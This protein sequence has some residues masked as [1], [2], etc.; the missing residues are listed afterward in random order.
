[1]RCN[2]PLVLSFC[3]DSNAVVVPIAVHETKTKTME[4]QL[5]C[6]PCSSQLLSSLISN[7]LEPVQHFIWNV[8]ATPVHMNRNISYE[9]WMQHP[10]TWTATAAVTP[11][12][13]QSYT[14][15]VWCN[16]PLVLSLFLESNAVVVPIAVHETKTVQPQLWWCAC[17]SQLLPSLISNELEPVQ[18][19]I[20]NE[21]W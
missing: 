14:S 10:F 16:V 8:E 11:C 19:F 21:A 3:S 5:W 2:M 17:S 12:K 15:Q 18:H 9:M 13:K 7:E 6:C 20:W 4:P 1:M